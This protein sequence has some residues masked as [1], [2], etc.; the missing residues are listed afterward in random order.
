M[1]HNVIKIQSLK[2]KYLESIFIAELMMISIYTLQM[3]LYNGHSPKIFS[4]F[5]DFMQIRFTVVLQNRL[6]PTYST[7]KY[8]VQICSICK[9]DTTKTHTKI[10]S[11]K[12]S[13]F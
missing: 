8:T 3:C 5:Q 11:G 13:R 6:H 10:E 2:M 12:T 7:I 1:E 9:T 4:F